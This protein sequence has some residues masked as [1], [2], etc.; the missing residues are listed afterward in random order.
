MRFRK[1]KHGRKKL[2]RYLFAALALLA[3]AALQPALAQC[4]MCRT[5]MEH[6]GAAAAR[7]L[8]VGIVVLLLPPVAVFCSI[9]AIAYK[10]VKGEEGGE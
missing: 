5:A 10:K 4:P 6:G 8:N 1:M 9:F 7:T 3:L 2:Y